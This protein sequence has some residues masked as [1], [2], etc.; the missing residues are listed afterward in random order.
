MSIRDVFIPI[1]E[2]YK[3]KTNNP[4]FPVHVAGNKVNQAVA[5]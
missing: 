1:R 5:R 3:K 4:D 2:I